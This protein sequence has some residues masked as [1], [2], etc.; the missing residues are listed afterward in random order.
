MSAKYIPSSGP[1]DSPLMIVGEAPG[2]KEEEVGEN[3]VGPSGQLTDRLLQDA[4]WSLKQCFKANVL[5]YRPPEND[6]KRFDE[7]GHT[8]EECEKELWGEISVIKPNCILA[9]GEI[10]LN[11]LTGKT[12]IGDWRGSILPSINGLPKVIPTLHPAALLRGESHKQGKGA[13]PYSARFYVLHD[14]ERAVEESRDPEYRLPSRNLVVARNSQDV[15]NFITQY[16]RL[17][18]VACD[19]EAS[20]SIPT[21]VSLAFNSYHSISIPLLSSESS[22]NNQYAIPWSEIK[23]ILRVLD[24]FFQSGIQLIGQNFKFDHKKLEMFG[25]RLPKNI[26]ADT[27]IMMH[28]LYPELPKS[29]AFIASIVT[30]EP[31]WKN[32][33]KE[34]NPAKD[35]WDQHYLYNAKDAAVNYECWERLD[36]QVK[37]RGLE[38]FT[39]KFLMNLHRFYIDIEN[40]GL[41]VDEVKRAQLENIYLA[42]QGVLQDKLDK[43]VGF[44]CNVKSI[45]DVPEALKRLKLPKRNYFDED[46]LVSLLGNHAKNHE[47]EEGLNLI[48]DIRRLRTAISNVIRF[49]RDFDGKSRTLYNIG[50][51]ETGRS[52][53]TKLS[54]PERPVKKGKQAIGWAF[55][56]LTKHGDIGSEIRTCIVP[57]KDWIFLEADLSQAEA[58]IVALLSNDTELMELFK[59]GEDIHRI[60]ANWTFNRPNYKDITEDER[61]IGKTSR[62]SGNYDVGKRK[63]ALTANSDAR[64]FGI[65]VKISEWRAG[66]ILDTFHQMSPKIRGVF[67]EEVRKAIKDTRM[68]TNAFGRQRIFMDR[69]EDAI[70]REGYA[71]IP[72]STVGDKLKSAAIE[73]KRRDPRIRVLIE[74]HDALLFTVRNNQ[75]AVED[76]SVLIKE[77]FEYPIDFERCTLKRSPLSIPCEIKIGENYRDLKKFK[78]FKWNQ[79]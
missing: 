61:F 39:Y 26:Y 49:N 62:H 66:K 33:G 76:A 64:K 30:K 52:S 13:Y 45:L 54:T 32:E 68:L 10:A 40:E 69:M 37:V 15:I 24:R 53:S 65:P 3:L 57:D 14:F 1:S 47:Q 36:E 55:Q 71:Q 28:A 4:K 7:T 73:I 12:G 2:W 34:F 21:C 75:S 74:A 5:R 27:M 19:I 60:T 35:K 25:F 29:L 63:F 46:T 38:K 42:R 8:W 77:E 6:L 59:R 17:T 67:H 44:V 72:Q 31:F 70:F 22:W 18:K 58:R 23:I 9:L 20:A 41:N 79:N 51:T 43:L 78:D 11:T 56:T 48:L 16:S 50:G